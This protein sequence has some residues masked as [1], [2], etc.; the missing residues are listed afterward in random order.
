MQRLETLLIVSV[1]V[2]A[3]DVVVEGRRSRSHRRRVSRAGGGP[4]QGLGACTANKGNCES[5]FKNSMEKTAGLSQVG[6]GGPRW[7]LA[8]NWEQK[9]L[10][11]PWSREADRD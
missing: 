10:R 6:K 11:W 5:L 8:K 3:A 4:R 9:L 2:S 7:V 1:D